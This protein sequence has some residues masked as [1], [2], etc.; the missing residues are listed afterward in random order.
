MAS[1]VGYFVLS[2]AT[3]ILIIGSYDG[4]MRKNQHISSLM[5]S[6]TN[7]NRAHAVIACMALG[8][9]VF[10]G[11][12]VYLWALVDGSKKEKQT[13]KSK[14]P[15]II[16]SV[17]APKTL[18]SAAVLEAA[19]IAGC[20]GSVPVALDGDREPPPMMSCGSSAHAHWSRSSGAGGLVHF[21]S[22]PNWKGKYR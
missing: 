19:Q 8:I 2:G 16:G 4:R 14:K 20:G 3:N 15:E 18:N 1:I 6:A 11:L 7:Y 13:T 21:G 22:R 9:V 10:G 12:V 5:I 17:S